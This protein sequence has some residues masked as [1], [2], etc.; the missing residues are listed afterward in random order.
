MSG[1]GSTEGTPTPTALASQISRRVNLVDLRT[2]HIRSDL[3]RLPE[4]SPLAIEI[5]QN[6]RWQRTE[7]VL[8][9]ELRFTI[10]VT[11]QPAESDDAGSS[12][13]DVHDAVKRPVFSAEVHL[14]VVYELDDD[15][16]EAT[17]EAYRAFGELSAKHTSYPYL[18][19]LVHSLTT[20]A[21]LPP[22]VLSSFLAPVVSPDREG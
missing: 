15:S 4:S 8:A 6:V 13:A 16:F 2:S 22:L 20:R 21:G 11:D 1:D 9:Y 19:E 3:H 17:D 7:D 5:G 18:R 12:G 14:A 10:D